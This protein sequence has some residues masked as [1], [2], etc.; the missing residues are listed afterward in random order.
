MDQKFP[1]KL[2]FLW[3]CSISLSVT[4]IILIFDLQ[5]EAVSFHISLHSICRAM[6]QGARRD[7]KEGCT[8]I[9]ANPVLAE[10]STNETFSAAVRKQFSWPLMIQSSANRL[11]QVFRDS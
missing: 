6:T 3:S 2:E 5:S 7:I 10:V 4:V 11:E 9:R 1:L 8:V